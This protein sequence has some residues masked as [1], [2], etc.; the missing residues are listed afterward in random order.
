M[1]HLGIALTSQEGIKCTNAWVDT[2][3]LPEVIELQTYFRISL[4]PIFNLSMY[5]YFSKNLYIL[6]LVFYYVTFQCGPY[7]IFKKN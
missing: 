7:N 2:E 4:Q 3:I 6:F 5:I 1:G